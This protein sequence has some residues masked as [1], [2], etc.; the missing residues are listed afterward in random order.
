MPKEQTSASVKNRLRTQEPHKYKVILH[1]D[2]LTPMDLVVMIL[3]T[4]FRKEEPE[5]VRLML[6]V[7][8]QGSAVAGVYSYD[9][10]VSKTRRATSIA[11]AE[12]YPLQLSCQP[13]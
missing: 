8:N 5:A 2:D 6:Q 9:I 7:H 3:I 11:R 1:N 4:V 10:A 12:G 13:E